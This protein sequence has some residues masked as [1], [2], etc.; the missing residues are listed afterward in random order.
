[1]ASR[2]IPLDF[3]P[4]IQR[5]GTN[6]DSD[7]AVDGR[8]VRWR[9]GRVRSQGGYRR[10]VD[11]LQGVPRQ[12]HMFYSG[13]NVY[14]HVGTSTS[15]EQI[16]LNA[17]GDVVAHNDRTPPDFAGG[18]EVGWTIDALFDGTSN[19]TQIIA[20]AVGDLENVADATPTLPFLGLITASTPLGNFSPQVPTGDEVYTPPAVAGGIVA[21]Q[22][23]LFDYDSNGFVGWSQPNLPNTLGLTGGS[24]GGG[25]ARISA[26][27]IVAGM[28]LRG[29]GANSPAALFWSLSEVL[30]ANFVGQ[31]NGIFAFN[32]V[33]P[34]S[35]ILG[36]DVVLEYDGL[37]FWAG[38]GRFQVYNGTVVE[39]PNKYNQDW[40]FDNLNWQFAGKTFA[41]KNPRY[42]E[43]GWCAPMFGNT[44]PSHAVIYNVR[45]NCW[46]DTEMTTQGRSAAHF[47]QGF[48]YPIMG[49]PARG[50]NGYDLWLHEIGTDEVRPGLPPVAIRK[51]YTTPYLSGTH[52]NPPTDE[53]MSIMQFEPDMTQTGD[54]TV[55]PTGTWNPKVPDFDDEPVPIK[56][57]ASTEQEQIP[58]FKTSR[59]LAAL[60]VESNTLGGSFITG[61][62]MLHADSAVTGR[63]TGGRGGT[64][65]KS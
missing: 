4:G 39:V 61:K 2:P 26:Q 6:L 30:S 17:N 60:R 34:E 55:T 42:G 62:N 28:P 18:P 31:S 10:L 47:A 53:A 20:H 46:Y 41:F 43:I 48:R 40:F 1:M 37:Y 8:W 14:V 49:S 23:Y 56:A 13:P 11:D 50:T 27:K 59:R 12:I 16:I 33:S 19:S 36:P 63:N 52:S 3:L 15:F 44:E 21:V 9:L 7:T 64:K 54:M 51:F 32:T 45:E 25:S 22:P 57:I 29:G 24:G 35:S 58:S 38:V 65:G 5:D